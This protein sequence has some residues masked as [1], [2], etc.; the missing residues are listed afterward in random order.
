M[1]SDGGGGK[2]E[3]GP[4]EPNRPGNVARTP[5]TTLSSKTSW[6]LSRNIPPLSLEPEGTRLEGLVL[7]PFPFWAVGYRLR[8]EHG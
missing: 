3:R 8:Q 2:G 7:V 6:I 5:S 1:S 4:R